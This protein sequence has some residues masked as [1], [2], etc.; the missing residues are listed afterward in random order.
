MI[1]CEIEPQENR[2]TYTVIQKRLNFAKHKAQLTRDN[3][4]DQRTRIT[5]L[6]PRHVEY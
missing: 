3:D 2:V 5:A 6:G 1:R 4:Q